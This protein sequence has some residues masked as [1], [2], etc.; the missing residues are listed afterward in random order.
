M[1]QA[2][3]QCSSVGQ[4]GVHR[5]PSAREASVLRARAE[6][7]RA[8]GVGLAG[9]AGR[10]ARAERDPRRAGALGAR[11]GVGRPRRAH[12]RA[13]LQV[14][15][16]GAEGAPH[17]GERR[18]RAP[19]RRGRSRQPSSEVGPAVDSQEGLGNWGKRESTVG[20][21][22][23]GAFSTPERGAGGAYSATIALARCGLV[24]LLLPEQLFVPAH[25]KLRVA[26]DVTP[27]AVRRGGARAAS[28][29]ADTLRTGQGVKDSDV[30]QARSSWTS[31]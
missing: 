14:R 11:A 1:T 29:L 19:V 15:A 28:H 13:P 16:P 4:P 21:G 30:F 12:H 7:L 24:D 5:E 23:P 20:S 22:A 27:A 2:D 8:H 9:A 17:P 25:T 31:R 26:E 18:A 3:R 6:R 10:R